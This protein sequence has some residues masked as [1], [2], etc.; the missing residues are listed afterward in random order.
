MSGI[1]YEDRTTFDV[2][3][4][5]VLVAEGPE[6]DVRGV[7]MWCEVSFGERRNDLESSHLSKSVT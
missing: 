3:W 6:F 7:T 4:E 5:W 1:T 2:G